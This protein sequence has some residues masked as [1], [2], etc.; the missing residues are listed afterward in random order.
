MKAHAPLGVSE[1]QCRIARRDRCALHNAQCTIA[2]R[3]SCTLHKLYDCTLNDCEEGWLQQ[4]YRRAC[5]LNSICC[6]CHS[7]GVIT[8]C[9]CNYIIRISKFFATTEHLQSSMFFFAHSD[10]LHFTELEAFPFQCTWTAVSRLPFEPVYF[11]GAFF[12]LV[13]FWG[14]SQ[15]WASFSPLTGPPAIQTDLLLIALSPSECKAHH[16]K[17]NW[18]IRCIAYILW[19]TS[20]YSSCKSKLLFFELLVLWFCL[21]SLEHAWT[22]LQVNVSLGHLLRLIS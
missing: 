14:V 3:D 10:R 15:K 9:C 1:D 21:H 7:T 5:L 8:H 6:W 13:Y 19:T 2:R 11:W 18:S 4:D 17:L 20:T 12:E 16:L 22:P